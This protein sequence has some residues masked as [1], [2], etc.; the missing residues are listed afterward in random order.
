[1]CSSNLSMANSIPVGNYLINTQRSFT[2]RYLIS[3]YSSMDNEDKKEQKYERR[4]LRLIQIRDEDCDGVAARIAERIKR[5]SSYVSR[6]MYPKGKPGRKRIAD[7]MREIIEVAFNKPKYWLDGEEKASADF[8]KH[9]NI[10]PAPDSTRR[11]PIISY[12]QAG[13]WTETTDP[14]HPGDADNWINTHLELSENAFGL[15]VKGD[16]MSPAF[17]EGDWIIID[18]AVQPRPG[19]YVVAKNGEEEATFK[20]YRPRGRDKDGNLIV[21]LVPENHDYE[22][23]RSDITPFVIIGTMV[24]SRKFRKK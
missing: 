20:K 21:E 6:M 1:M 4:R 5:E 23:L 9:K 7:D 16:S 8:S 19:D 18:P 24:E 13:V 12:V 17:N 2:R 10:I 11:V 22:S 15:I 3:N 14:H